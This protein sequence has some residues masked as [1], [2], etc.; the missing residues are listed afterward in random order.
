MKKTVVILLSLFI[1]ITAKAQVAEFFSFQ[2][3]SLNKDSKG[4]FVEVKEW[5][6]QEVYIN[7]DLR[8]KKVQFFSKGMLDR[9]T[10]RLIREILVS[11]K[12]ASP[13]IINDEAMREFAGIDRWGK[14]CIVRL[15]LTKDAYKTQDGELRVEYADNAKVYKLRIVRDNPRFNKS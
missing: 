11:Q 8:L 12:S 14:H 7:F 9:D 6:G 15:R 1:F 10:F 13:D 5:I 3:A 2:S 4:N